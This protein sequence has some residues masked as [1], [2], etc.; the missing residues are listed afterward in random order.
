M[1]VR[2]QRRGC[3]QALSQARTAWQRDALGLNVKQG[4]D[5]VGDG[6]SG[7]TL[8][9]KLNS[10]PL[11]TGQLNHGKRIPEYL[12]SQYVSVF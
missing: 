7:L 4:K 6:G 11:G 2:D 1:T 8:T 9:A 12:K 10:N 5:T 3:L